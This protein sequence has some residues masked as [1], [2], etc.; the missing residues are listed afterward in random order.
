[1]IELEAGTRCLCRCSNMVTEHV[2]RD[3]EALLCRDSW[4]HSEQSG[5]THFSAPSTAATVTLQH[6]H[7]SW[8]VTAL[9]SAIV[10]KNGC[11]SC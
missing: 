6:Q 1:M 10:C 5:N 8:S 7:R 2:G 4:C 3:P 9:V 11:S